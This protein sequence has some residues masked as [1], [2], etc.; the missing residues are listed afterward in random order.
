M[1]PIQ[2]SVPRR[3]VPGMLYIWIHFDQ[4]ACFLLR[5]DAAPA[6]R[7]TTFLSLRELCGRASLILTGAA[8]VGFPVDGYWTILT[9]QFLHGGWLHII[10][11]MWTR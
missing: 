1:F 8:Y 9:Y 7:R 6:W 2:D 5:V 11:N 10:A 4:R 3:A